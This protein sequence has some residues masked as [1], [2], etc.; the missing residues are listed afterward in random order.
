MKTHVLTFGRMNPPTIGHGKLV[1]K[2]KN[3][4]YNKIRSGMKVECFIHRFRTMISES[5]VYDKHAL[6]AKR[7][8]GLLQIDPSNASLSAEA[9]KYHL[10]SAN[11]SPNTGLKDF[12][13]KRAKELTK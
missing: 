7:L 5:Y 11:T 6:M 8:D 4:V 13:L 1:E 12:H 2:V 3:E 10:R 9:I